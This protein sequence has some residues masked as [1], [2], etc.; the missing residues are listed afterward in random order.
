MNGAPESSVSAF[1]VMAGGR[2]AQARV[3]SAEDDR[4]TGRENIRE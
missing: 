4:K 3:D 2:R 1:E